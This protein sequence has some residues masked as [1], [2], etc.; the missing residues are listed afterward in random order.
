MGKQT[1]SK[2]QAGGKKGNSTAPAPTSKQLYEQAMLALQYDDYDS[3]K[4]CLKRA[5]KQ[6]PQNLEIVE[7]LGAL[8]AEIGP[9]NEAIQVRC[10]CLCLCCPS[11][12]H[13]LGRIHTAVSRRL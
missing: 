3:A 4:K 11:C 2:R 7:T 8:L 12:F 5:A 10:L 9:V 13:I 1:S 6:E